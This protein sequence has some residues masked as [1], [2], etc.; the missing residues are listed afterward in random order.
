MSLRAKR[1]EL[2]AN[3]KNGK[4]FDSQ[5]LRYDNNFDFD[6]LNTLFSSTPKSRLNG[7]FHNPLPKDILQ[8]DKITAIISYK[9]IQKELDWYFLRSIRYN[10]EITRFVEL[11][12]DFEISLLN[13]E[14]EQ[15]HQILE[16]IDNE[17]CV[18]FWG[19]KARLLLAELHLGTEK[20]KEILQEISAKQ[21]STN[22]KTLLYYTSLRFEMDLAATKYDSYV[23]F[24]LKKYASSYPKELADYVKFTFLPI[25]VAQNYELDFI[26]GQNVTFSA[27]DTYLELKKIVCIIAANNYEMVAHPYLDNRLKKLNSHIAD[28][29]LENLLLKINN[30][31]VVDPQDILPTAV[32]LLANGK[33]QEAIQI[34][35]NRLTDFPNDY[36]LYLPLICSV[37]H[38]GQKITDLFPKENTLTEV[39]VAIGNTFQKGP[40][41]SEDLEYLN[42]LYYVFEILDFHLPLRSI[43]S[44]ESYN[45]RNPK[46]AYFFYLVNHSISID[47][48]SYLKK[49]IESTPITTEFKLRFDVEILINE[50]RYED[51]VELL[52]NQLILTWSTRNLN[53][54]GWHSKNKLRA[55]IELNRLSEA[56]DIVV[57]FFF[58]HD[59]I[60]AYLVSNELITKLQDLDGEEIYKSSSIPILFSIYNLSSSLIYDGI[61][62]F[63]IQNGLTSPSDIISKLHGVDRERKYYLLHQVCTINNIQDSPYLSTIEKVE[64]ERIKILTHLKDEKPEK[65]EE[66][67]TEIFEITQNATVRECLKN[68]YDSRIYVDTQSLKTSLLGNLSDYFERY[69]G[70]VDFTFQDYSLFTFNKGKDNE[71]TSK[72][73]S[74]IA[75]FNPPVPQNEY[76]LYLLL[77]E[78]RLK[79][80]NSSII[81]VPYSRYLA[82]RDI[83]TNIQKEFLFNEDY[84]LKFFL[85]MRIRH[86]TLPNLL[87][88]VFERHNLLINEGI[89]R[90]RTIGHWSEKTA[91]VSDQ[92]HLDELVFLLEKFTLDIDNITAEGVSW[93]KIKETDTDNQS[94]FTFGFSEA[95]MLDIFRN[96]MGHIDRFDVL[97]DKTFENLWRRV[98]VIL[99]TLKLRFKNDLLD[100]YLSR[101]DRLEEEIDQ[102]FGV[103]S[104]NSAKDV[105]ASVKTDIQV[106]VHKSLGWFNIS[107]TKSIGEI[108]IAAIVKTSHEYLNI[109][110]ADIF[111]KVIVYSETI[112]FDQN[113]KGEFF[114]VL[115]DLFNTLL[116]N[117]IKHTRGLL[118][119][120]CT[121]SVSK[122]VSD[123]VIDIKNDYV[124]NYSEAELQEWATILNDKGK[125][126]ASFENKSGFPKLK[127][128]LSNDFSFPSYQISLASEG[129][130]FRVT[131]RI[132]HTNLVICAA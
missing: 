44:S 111:K 64:E 50:G 109:I 32:S 23:E 117:V 93:V 52:E 51:A 100:R 118:F 61:A 63:L 11:K 3:V 6:F 92:F 94:M 35:T 84:G 19:L 110:H 60:F 20:N 56:A 98:S 116:D 53:N 48:L 7:L 103:V 40:N 99:E 41:Y 96:E 34:L 81:E 80:I 79:W 78:K 29:H 130:S 21:V 113:I 127:R 55:L 26:L 112:T 104:F 33:T 73:Q 46:E 43:W 115:C 24:H 10:E 132:K 114:S 66:L 1:R 14:F 76:D 62:N 18:S 37:L 59:K 120:Q 49:Q 124:R 126:T 27:V 131:I 9:K 54:K 75:Y 86:G 22:L 25:D 119:P 30:S 70:I 106:A 47:D 2:I 38:T 91:E 71:T 128:L 28:Q 12:A 122:D 8:L 5:N 121:L 57:D 87:K 101:I 45:V 69:L 88:N 39:L 95:E 129:E 68:L 31:F 58:T 90:E 82:F 16:K 36:N 97:I 42:K 125:Y 13:S 77:L 102:L 85:S 72:L 83:Y 4:K 89:G 17:V 65:I 105:L 108:P 15:A 107:K 67:N 123:L 74:Y